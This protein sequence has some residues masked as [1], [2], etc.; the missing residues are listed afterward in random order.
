M[1]KDRFPYKQILSA[2][3]DAIVHKKIVVRIVDD[4]PDT[5]FLI[6]L[7]NQRITSQPCNGTD[8]NGCCDQWTINRSYLEDVINTPD[9][10]IKNPAK[11]NWEW[12][13]SAE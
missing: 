5:R 12:L 3:Q 9:D 10:Y 1:N 2:A 4:I 6:E 13:Q 8:C 11:L 7:E